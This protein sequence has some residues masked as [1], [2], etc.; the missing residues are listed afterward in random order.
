M[1]EL[2]RFP[3]L[4]VVARTAV[5]PSLALVAT[6]AV[7][8]RFCPTPVKVARSVNNDGRLL[9]S[10]PLPW[11]IISPAKIAHR[12]R[13][14]AYTGIAPVFCEIGAFRPFLVFVANNAG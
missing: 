9:P 5:S 4:V 12:R 14:P 10:L 13:F 11:R 3:F 2:G 1:I 8:G 6:V 7:D